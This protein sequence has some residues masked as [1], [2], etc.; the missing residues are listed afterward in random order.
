MPSGTNMEFTTKYRIIEYDP[1]GSKNGIP[2]Q[3]TIY[4]TDKIK[5]LNP[6]KIGIYPPVYYQQFGLGK[7]WKG[8]EKVVVHNVFA[9]EL[10]II[11]QNGNVLKVS[12]LKEHP[13]LLGTIDKQKYIK[14]GRE[15]VALSKVPRITSDQAKQTIIAKLKPKDI[16]SLSVFPYKGGEIICGYN[17]VMPKA[18]PVWWLS[19]DGIRNVNGIAREKTPQF[20][21]AFEVGASEGYD[22][23]AKNASYGHQ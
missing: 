10:V 6:Q 5:R 12:R 21:L 22:F 13:K 11:L 4:D 19:E 17:T 3:V 20:E 1:E 23:C 8:V 16:W 14:G 2:E 18:I 9:P 15:V 7:S